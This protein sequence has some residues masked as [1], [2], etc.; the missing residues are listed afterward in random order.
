MVVA[1]PSL[2]PVIFQQF[3]INFI[4]DK[5]RINSWLKDAKEDHILLLEFFL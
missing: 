5:S 1:Q 3:T 2:F 4:Y